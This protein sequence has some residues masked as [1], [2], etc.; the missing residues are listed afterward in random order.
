MKSHRMILPFGLAL[1]LS[2]L[3]SSYDNCVLQHMQGVSSDDAAISIKEA[4]IRTVEEPIPTPAMKSLLKSASAV[5]GKVP[6]Y[7]PP[8]GALYVSLN[9]NSGYTITVLVFEVLD[10]K[11]N[12]IERYV[13]RLFVAPPPPGVIG[14]IFPKDQT[15]MELIPPGPSE[16]YFAI[17]QTTRDPNKWG[18]AYG[19]K[20]VSAK[21]FRD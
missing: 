14:R 21:G 2:A 5:Y 13:I 17:R 4:C 16:F 8:G 20:I 9:N 3:A 7:D 12:A 19:W 6:P 18:A 15:K 1:A 10:K 11:T